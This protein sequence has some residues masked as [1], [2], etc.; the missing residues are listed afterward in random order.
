MILIKTIAMQ[1]QV[2]IRN[3]NLKYGNINRLFTRL[4][5]NS[6]IVACGKQMM[7]LFIFHN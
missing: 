4:R 7:I 3:N 6:F 5:N 2:R 1:S